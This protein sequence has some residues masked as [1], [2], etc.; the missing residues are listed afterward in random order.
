MRIA[1][2]PTPS[3]D[4]GRDDVGEVKVSDPRLDVVSQQAPIQ[5]G[6]P[7]AQI[8][9]LDP[10]GRVLPQRHPSG[11]RIEPIATAMSVSVSDRN[12][13]ASLSPAE[14]SALP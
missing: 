6:G 10:P 11:E 8:S 14:W 12:P 7:H 13:S 9:L 3:P 1:Q 4:R 5:L 2:P